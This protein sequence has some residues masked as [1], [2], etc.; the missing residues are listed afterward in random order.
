MPSIGLLITFLITTAVFAY[1][2]GPAML[3]AAAQT[4]A[5]GRWSGLMATLGIHIGG[6]VHVAAA[7]VGLS[8]L[9]H[10]VPTLYLTVKLAGAAYLIWMGISL[11]RAK[12]QGDV[13]LPEMQ[14]KSGRRA[15]FESIIVEVLNPKTAIF[16]VAFL[17][18]FVDASATLPV[19]AQ[20]VVLGSIVNL[21]FSSADVL[22][23]VLAGALLSRLR[24][25]RRTRRLVQRLGGVT[26]IGLG[27]HLA[28]QKS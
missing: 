14:A 1:V 5:R 11:F 21:M 16:F 24:R 6:Y 18:Q 8:A 19:W 26:L 22:C 10:A 20:F 17:P 13:A 3:Y 27:T 28:L 25:S 4:M 12:A 9:F 2:P 15:F 7:A 23:V